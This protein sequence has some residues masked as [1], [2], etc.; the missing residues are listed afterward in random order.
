[1]P[2]TCTSV[3]QN[4][5]A[6]QLLWCRLW[7]INLVLGNYLRT[8]LHLNSIH[9]SITVVSNPELQFCIHLLFEIKI[10]WQKNFNNFPP[11]VS[12]FLN[13]G[14][15]NS[16]PHLKQYF[17]RIFTPENEITANNH[18]RREQVFLACL[19]V[20][21][22]CMFSAHFE[23]KEKVKSKLVIWPLKMFLNQ[24]PYPFLCSFYN[25]VW[26]YLL[27]QVLAYFQQ[28]L[29]WY[30]NVQ[31][32][33][34]SSPLIPS[35]SGPSHFTQACFRHLLNMHLPVGFKNTN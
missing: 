13:F 33:I 35:L 22:S 18:F 31:L 19:Y 9:K 24:I 17:L 28:W 4:M 11:F 1:M 32:D 27:F 5:D 3:L 23:Q 26:I 12:L 16:L 7:Y 25:R 29:W 21:T 30:H 14:F 34:S 6:K 10:H 8:Q 20:F 2:N 15:D